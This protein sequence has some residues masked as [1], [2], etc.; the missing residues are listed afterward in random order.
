MTDSERRGKRGTAVGGLWE[1]F[2]AGKKPGISLYPETTP[3]PSR[4]SY[5]RDII[6]IPPSLEAPYAP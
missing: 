3:S 4:T 2:G 6:L 5:R 1:G